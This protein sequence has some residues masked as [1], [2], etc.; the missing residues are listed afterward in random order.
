[1][2]TNAV[3]NYQTYHLWAFDAPIRKMFIS[4]FVVMFDLIYFKAKWQ[5]AIWRELSKKISPKPLVCWLLSNQGNINN[6]VTGWW[7]LGSG[8]WEIIII[9]GAIFPCFKG[10][11][12]NNFTRWS[13]L[14]RWSVYTKLLE[15]IMQLHVRHDVFI[16]IICWLILGMATFFSY[17]YA[18]AILVQQCYIRLF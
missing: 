15:N 13:M 4:V 9:S 17:H 2:I 12:L 8:W 18:M 1:M 11:K 10:V 3:T 16:S 14:I 6:N 5:Y 7:G